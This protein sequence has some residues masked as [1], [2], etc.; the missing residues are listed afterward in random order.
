MRMANMKEIEKDRYSEKYQDHNQKLG[1]AQQFRGD[2]GSC[3]MEK[4]LM[5]G[6]DPAVQGEFSDILQL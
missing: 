4:I 3:D 6:D 2:F 1:I 5:L